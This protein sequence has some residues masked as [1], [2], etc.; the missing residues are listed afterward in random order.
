MPEDT[1]PKQKKTGW[2]IIALVLALLRDLVR[3]ALEFRGHHF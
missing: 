2:E 3:L 1:H